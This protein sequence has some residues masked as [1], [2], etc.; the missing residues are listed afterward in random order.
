MAAIQR[1]NRREVEAAAEREG[2][3]MRAAMEAQ[4]AQVGSAIL[5][6]SERAIGTV[7]QGRTSR[8]A[9]GANQMVQVGGQISQLQGQVD[10]RMTTSVGGQIN[11]AARSPGR[12]ANGTDGSANRSFGCPNC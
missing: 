7:A 11:S 3:K 8:S 1:D 12:S 6:T 9:N 4:M 2:G 10:Q 5:D